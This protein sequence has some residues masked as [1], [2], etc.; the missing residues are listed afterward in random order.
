MDEIAVNV[1]PFVCERGEIRYMELVRPTG[2]TPIPPLL[3][4]L[5][6]SVGR[7]YQDLLSA[8]EKIGS[9]RRN[10]LKLKP[11]RIDNSL[12]ERL[13]DCIACWLDTGREGGGCGG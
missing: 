10:G 13:K 4:Q 7:V 1:D 9:S 12:T 2:K 3:L 8:E 11:P 5:P 6:S